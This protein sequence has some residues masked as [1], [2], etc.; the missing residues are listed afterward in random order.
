MVIV[1]LW[2]LVLFVALVANVGQAVNRKIALQTI[3]DAG[4]YTGATKMAEGMNYIAYANGTIQDY[5][6]LATDAWLAN[7]IALSTCSGFDAINEA[8][9]GLYQAM[10]IPIQLLNGFGPVGYGGT[11]AGGLVHSEAVRVSNYNAADLFPGETLSFREPGLSDS[12][13]QELG[14]MPPS[15]DLLRLVDLEEVPDGTDPNTKF[16]S[17]PPLGSGST[18]SHTQPCLTVCGL[19]PCVLPETWSFNVWYK[20]SSTKVKYFTWIAEAPATRVMIFDAF[21]GPNAM[22]KMTAAAAA[23]PVGGNIEKGEPRYVAQ[24]VP[25]RRVMTFGGVIRDPMSN[26][27]G[28]LRVVTH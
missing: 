3:A 8:Y 22:P 5:W 16:P 10:N 13:D 7:T 20:K 2:V 4:A 14:S 23:R 11:M 17:L 12:F 27:P 25:L 18:T 26:N 1:M 9:Q 28:G 19:V 15:R 24:M 21:F 6:A